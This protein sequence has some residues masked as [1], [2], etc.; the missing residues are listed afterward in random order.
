ME[1]QIKTWVCAFG[2]RH[3]LHVGSFTNSRGKP[4]WSAN[5]DCSDKLGIDGFSFLKWCQKSYDIDHSHQI[6]QHMQNEFL[7]VNSLSKSK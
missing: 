2:T 5:C 6:Q 7:R 1:L 3:S 4:D